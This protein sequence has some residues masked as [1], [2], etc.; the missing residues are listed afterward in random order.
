MTGSTLTAPPSRGTWST[1]YDSEQDNTEWGR[2]S[3]TADIPADGS[4]EVFASSSVDGV[5][6][7]DSTG[8][9]NGKVFD[10]PPGRFIKTEVRLIRSS[11]GESPVVSDL[12]I[13]AMALSGADVTLSVTI[14]GDVIPLTNI[15]TGVMVVPVLSCL[16]KEENRYSA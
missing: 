14:P 2:I 9:E 6:F 10:L 16:I 4:V 15:S 8:V 3:W 12:T 7:S 13:N 11:D 5:N 1:V